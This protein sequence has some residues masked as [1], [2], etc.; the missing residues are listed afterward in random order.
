M[1]LDFNWI[2]NGV[3]QGS[4][5][6][7]LSE[8]FKRVDVV[9]FCAEEKQPPKGLRPPPGKIIYRLGFDDDIYRP[10]PPEAGQIFHQAA[11]QLAGYIRSGKR[12]LITCAMGLNR[13][14]LITGLTLMHAF[15]MT[16][17]DAIRLI[18]GRRGKDALMNP[19]FERWLR[20]QQTRR[21]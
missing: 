8:A 4:Y 18:R 12:V 21:R 11:A 16:P 10:I 1:A 2:V 9:V 15:G 3:A 19:V 17:N 14:G 7:P 13:S 5:P 20:N 6:N